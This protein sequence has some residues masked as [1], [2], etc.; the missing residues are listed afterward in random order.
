MLQK[1]KVTLWEKGKSAVKNRDV[2]E[3]RNQKKSKSVAKK[4]ETAGN[5]YNNTYINIYNYISIV[6]VWNPD[7]STQL[8]IE[9]SSEDG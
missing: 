6:R 5:I 9:K 4:P 2:W 7:N 3:A 1:V 8:F